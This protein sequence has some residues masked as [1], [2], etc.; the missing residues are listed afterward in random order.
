MDNVF[1]YPEW[2]GKFK[3][4]TIEPPV[5]KRK[6][7]QY[8]YKDIVCAF[9]IETSRVPGTDDSV[10]YIWQFQIDMQCTIYGRTWE[11]FK[12][13]IE[14]LESCLDLQEAIVVYVH[15]LSFEFQF[16]SGI[17]NFTEDSVFCVDSRKILR[18]TLHNH[19]EFRDSYL[20][21]NMSLSKF[22]ENMQVEDQ[23]LKDFDYSKKRYWFTELSEHELLYCVN[24]VRGLVQAIK[25]EMEKDGDT[26]YTI[27]LTSTGYVR[28]D[29]RHAMQYRMEDIK[30]LLPDYEL[31]KLLREA[32]RGG[33]VHA[34]RFYVGQVLDNVKSMDRSSSYPETQVNLK[35]P[36]S[37]FRKSIE[38][39]WERFVDLVDRHRAVVARISLTNVKLRQ[40]EWGCPYIPVDKCRNVINAKEDNGRILSA[41]YLEIS[42][43][44]I[45]FKIVESEYEWTEQ[46]IKDIYYAK[47]GKLPQEAI[48]LINKLYTD[49]TELKDVEGQEYF[50]LKSKNK[51][52]SV[53]G[54]TAQD[55]M[56]DNVVYRNGNYEKA[57]REQWA[58][59][60]AFLPY[61]WGVWCT[62][63]ARNELEYC[64]S[65]AHKQATF[66]YC[67]TDSVK[68]IGNINLE[69]YNKT[70][71]ELAE[72]NGGKATD[73]H[74]VTHY[75]GV[76]EQEHTADRFVAWGAKK[77]ACQYGDDIKITIAGVP[78]K[79]GAEELKLAGGL[80]RLQPS[81]TFYAGKLASYYNDTADY[82][83]D[84]DGHDVHVTKN[85]TLK[86]T[87]YIL[88]IADKYYDI[89]QD[90]VNYRKAMD[91]MRANKRHS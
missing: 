61:Q 24:D 74:G 37:P 26:L 30:K 1:Y 42:V 58:L 50:Y 7:K 68:Y 27:P 3:A 71:I 76:Y 23:K 53:Y 72:Y 5:K 52:N 63:H 28:R 45:D 19:I 41:D 91:L 43:T 69:E 75:M 82:H 4:A 11:Q 13:F 51:I 2:D 86:D 67:D 22:L 36:I 55:P 9:D 44:D 10:M 73:K 66:I 70:K 81:Y 20:H 83:I 54:M 77:Y 78:K 87:Q 49:K 88:S 48:K 60:S 57:E 16:L 17:F 8:F 34:N 33:N 85:V 56:K 31:Y 21:S 6:R 79:K 32:F 47:Y 35:F 12:D 84:I 29:F 65:E 64:I 15:N 39:S 59:K 40:Y 62:A 46:G 25:T 89:L 90:A 80:D 18:A 14:Y 38:Q